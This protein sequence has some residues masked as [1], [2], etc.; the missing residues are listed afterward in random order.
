MM[1]AVEAPFYPHRSPAGRSRPPFFSAL[2]ALAV[3]DRDRRAC[4]PR[5]LLAALHIE[6]VMNAIERAVPAPELEVVVPRRARRQVLGDSP[7]LA[8]CAEDVHQPVHHLAHVHRALVAATFARPDERLH[9]APFLI[10]Q[11]ARIPQLAA[12]VPRT[13]L[14]RPHRQPL[15]DSGRP[16]PPILASQTLDPIQ[17]LPEQA[18][19]VA[20]SPTIAAAL[21]PDTE[22][23][24][25]PSPLPN[26]S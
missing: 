22:L 23:R 13:V 19:S 14:D 1:R 11:I 3:N 9:M 5:G 25:L 2:H 20:A 17:Y 8:A 24:S 12:V 4:L 10:R 16:G 7:P 18:L 26:K 21:R 6:R 15:H